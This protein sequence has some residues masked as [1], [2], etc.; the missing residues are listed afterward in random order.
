MRPRWLPGRTQP[1]ARARSERRGAAQSRRNP[2]PPPPRL[3]PPPLTRAPH[4]YGQPLVGQG[5]HIDAAADR[6]EQ[7]PQAGDAHRGVGARVRERRA[8]AATT[9]TPALSL[10]LSL[11]FFFLRLYLRIKSNITPGR[12]AVPASGAQSAAPGPPH[13]GTGGRR[14]VEECKKK[15]LVKCGRLPLPPHPP[16]PPPSP[17]SLRPKTHA[18]RAR[19][20][21]PVDAP[22]HK[23]THT[24]HTSH[25][26]RR[27]R[28]GVRGRGKGRGGA[29][30]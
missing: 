6:L 14:R 16:H 23:Y 24:Q 25:L 27:T 20:A 13:P 8:A 21:P 1:A 7:G 18:G 10:S 12:M 29:R 2:P 15:L 30:S 3:P 5:L 11:R 4:T 26:Y 9:T 17:I 19:P 22:R 28:R